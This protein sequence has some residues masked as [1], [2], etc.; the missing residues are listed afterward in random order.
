M[1]T[2]QELLKQIQITTF[3]EK[4]AKRIAVDT[5]SGNGMCKVYI[6]T[7]PDIWKLVEEIAVQIITIEADERKKL[8]SPV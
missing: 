8:W 4:Y 5:P 6:L 2:Q 1:T 3:I 7:G